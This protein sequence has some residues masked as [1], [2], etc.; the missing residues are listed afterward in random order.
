MHAP[1][2]THMREINRILRY[3]KGTPRRGL[4]FKKGE[5]TGIEIF[6]DA[7][8]AGTSDDKRSY[9]SFVLGDLVTWKSKK[10]NVLSRSSAKAE[11]RD[12]THGIC[13]SI[14]LKML[15]EE[16]GIK[17]QLPIRIHCDNKAAIS[18]S[19]N[20]I[21]HKCSKHVEVD[22]HFIKENIEEGPITM[23]YV[24]TFEQAADILTKALF[25]PA[26]EK[27]VDKLGLYNLYS[28]A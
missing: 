10:Q 16:M 9:C 7:D 12:T 6:S 18:I 1:L 3:L 14:W 4:F 28:P 25:K 2:E 20:P 23:T 17:I 15:L 21:H 26:F 27:L 5:G 22:R 11:L 19:H 24:P 8:W 13:E